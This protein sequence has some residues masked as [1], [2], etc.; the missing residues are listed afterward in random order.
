MPI[1]PYGGVLFATLA[2]IGGALD[3]QSSAVAPAPTEITPTEITLSADES[4]TVGNIRAICAREDAEIISASADPATGTTL[5]LALVNKA[6][7]F[8]DGGVVEIASK[9]LRVP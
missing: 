6:G 1:S 5:H 4:A 7:D 9:D 3:S 2:T 8:L